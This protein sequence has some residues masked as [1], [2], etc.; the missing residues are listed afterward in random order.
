MKVAEDW[1]NGTVTVLGTVTEL[2]ELEVETGVPPI[3]AGPL[4]VIVPVELVPPTTVVG[5]KLSEMRLTGLIASDA[6]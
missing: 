1:P 2:V 5:D 6:V 3:P 4:R